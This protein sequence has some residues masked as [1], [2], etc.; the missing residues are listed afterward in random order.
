MS[1][2]LEHPVVAVPP[3]SGEVARQQIRG[4]SLL[5]VGRVLSIGVNL[6]VQVLI[7]RYLSK[8]DYG[9]F[10]Y[11]LS[12]V[13]AGQTVVTLGLDRAVTRFLPLYHE[14]QDDARLG[15]TL[16][17]VLGTIALLGTVM[18]AAVWGMHTSLAAQLL[19]EETA[20][21]VQLTATLLMIMI[22][23]APIQALDELCAALFAIFSG[24]R[25]IFFRKYLLA[26][27][28]KLLV[29]ALLIAGQGS[30]L[31]LASGYVLA[32]VVGVVL[33]GVWLVRSLQ[34]QG[35]LQ[36]LRATALQV[37]WRDV[38]A[39][40]IPLLSS[41]LV[42]VV[43]TSADTLLLG[44]FWSAG[45]VA[46]FRVVQ[47]A[48]VLNQVV[49]SSFTVLFTPLAARLWARQDHAGINELYWQTAVWIAVLSFPIFVATFALARPLTVVLYGER[50]AN[51]AIMLALLALAYYIN[52]AL[53]FN[54]LT[55]K[56]FGRLK[57]ILLI[58]LGVALLNLA[59]NLWLIPRYGALGAAVG[60]SLALIVH[61]A[62]K[63]LGLR[64][65]TG[66]RL[67]DPRYAPIYVSMSLATLGVVLTQVLAGGSL[68]IGVMAALVATL[69]VVMRARQAL[70]LDQTFPELRRI[71]LMRRL[72]R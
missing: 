36:R 34:R 29:V 5:L 70:R 61:N 56:I 2:S 19:R 14:Q 35:L 49:L 54:G 37:P 43:M 20:G 30:V 28:L 25:A 4:S 63:Q 59:L 21:D 55:L 11:V 33:Y 66:I 72:W 51:S 68:P 10:A 64:L 31:F 24:P 18:V 32:A 16:V 57:Y 50:Y 48:A 13:T 60:T 15:G 39:F 26:P 40:T 27:G 44:Y 12:L 9:A 52:A 47:P 41:D 38:L 53:G 1:H 71:P 62:L 46:A 42:A 3:R 7:V 17:M 69:L 6:L 22:V 58:N 8:Q 65:G 67:F 23:L 45:E